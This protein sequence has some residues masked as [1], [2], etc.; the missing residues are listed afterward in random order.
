MLAE[1][2]LYLPL[3]EG[4]ITQTVARGGVEPDPAEF[5]KLSARI[6]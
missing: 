2:E 4:D 6:R 5:R 1:N 3:Y